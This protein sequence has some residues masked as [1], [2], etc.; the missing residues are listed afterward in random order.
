VGIPNYWFNSVKAIDLILDFSINLNILEIAL[1][2]LAPIFSR[3][4]HIFR[5]TKQTFLNLSV[6]MEIGKRIVYPAT[7]FIFSARR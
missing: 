4:S 5:Q 7:N 2:K 1:Y 6:G 3:P